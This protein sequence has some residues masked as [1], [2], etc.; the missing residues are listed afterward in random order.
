MHSFSSKFHEAKKLDRLV[1][2]LVLKDQKNNFAEIREDTLTGLM[3]VFQKSSENYVCIKKI[4]LQ[5]DNLCF[6][7]ICKNI[8]GSILKAVLLFP[9]G[10]LSRYGCIF[11]SCFMYLQ[12]GRI[13]NCSFQN[14]TIFIRVTECLI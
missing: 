1:G 13:V 7:C 12:L 11:M 2:I 4:V 3:E 6:T 8:P 5:K 10:Q 14:K 9:F